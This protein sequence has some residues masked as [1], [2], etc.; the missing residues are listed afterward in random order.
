MANHSLIQLGLFDNPDPRPLPLI[1]A[2][3][4]HFPLQHYEPSQ[5][6]P[7]C[8]YAV[9]DW[10]MGMGLTKGTSAKVWQKQGVE[11]ESIP[12]SYSTKGGQQT[13]P[14]AKA[15]ILY[16]LAQDMRVTKSNPQLAEI[17]DYLA[18]AGVWLDSARRDPETA[19]HALLSAA[20]RQRHA[21]LEKYKKYGLADKPEVKRLKLRTDSIDTFN[22]LMAVIKEVVTRAH[23]TPDYRGIIDAENLAVLGMVSSGL[24]NL[25]KTK[26]VR[27][28][29]PD[30]QLSALQ[31]G[32]FCLKQFLENV[33]QM[34][35]Q[36]VIMAVDTILRP[37]GE[38]LESVCRLMGV[39][40]VTGQK[41]LKPNQYLKEDE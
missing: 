23:E 17:K 8:V 40:R 26:S 11:L 37:I 21:E 4:W 38:H 9:Q 27:D 3:K 36:Q 29:L 24:R 18:A 28:A 31:Y 32:E 30:M 34:T 25:L 15:D 22:D 2:E 13:S 33:D 19:A 14:F 6:I 35:N 7:E 1:V 41:L 10:L 39:H 20:S 16:R 12:L 5:A